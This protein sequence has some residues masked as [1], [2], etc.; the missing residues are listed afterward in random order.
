MSRYNNISLLSLFIS[1][2]VIA[3]AVFGAVAQ[4]KAQS[5]Q[6][7]VRLTDIESSKGTMML[8][9][10]NKADGFPNDHTKAVK[11]EKLPAKQGTMEISFGFL[12]A[13]TYGLAVYHD[14]DSNG[15]LNTNFVGAPTE[16]YAFSNNFKPKF[17]APKFA[18]VSFNLIQPLQLNLKL[19]Y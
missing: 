11:L 19:R 9:L 8:A 18:D 2:L 17:S 4:A 3:L 13:G 14:E 15:K 6:L 7:S 12:P 16:G 5:P 10:F 1:I